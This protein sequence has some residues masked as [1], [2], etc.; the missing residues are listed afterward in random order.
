[1]TDPASVIHML[2]AATAPFVLTAAVLVF[3][4]RAAA[5]RRHEGL[6]WLVRIAL[7]SNAWI[8]VLVAT[9]GL[10]LVARDDAADWLF[11]DAIGPAES[12]LRGM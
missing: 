1:M 12:R 2:L 3:L 6:A 9:Y 4:A 7:V 10:Q 11:M 5:R 8:V